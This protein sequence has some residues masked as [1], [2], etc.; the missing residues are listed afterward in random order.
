MREQLTPLDVTFGIQQLIDSGYIEDDESNK[1]DGERAF[2]G[3][4][5]TTALPYHGA[6]RLKLAGNVEKRSLEAALLRLQIEV[7][8]DA[9]FAL[10]VTDDYLR[11]ELSNIRPPWLLVKP[12]GILGSVGPLFL[13]D[14]GP[15]WHCLAARLRENPEVRI[16]QEFAQ[17]W[18][19]RPY[20]IASLSSTS[21]T[22]LQ[23]A[24]TEV[25]KYLATGGTPHLEGTLIT[26]DALNLETRRHMLPRREGCPHCSAPPQPRAAV[27]PTRD[28]DATFHRFEHHISPVTGIV[29]AVG[30]LEVAD[31]SRVHVY[32]AVH[33]FTLQYGRKSSPARWLGSRSI[34]KGTTTVQ[35]RCSSLCEGLERYSGCWRGCETARFCSAEELGDPAVPIESCLLF[36]DCQYAHRDEWNR[37]EGDYNFVPQRFDRARRVAWTELG[38]LTHDRPRYLPA[39]FCYYNVPMEEDHDF[40]RSDSNGNAAGDSLQGAILAGIFEVVERDA[41]AIWWYNQALRSGVEIESFPSPYFSEL[42][43]DYARLDRH[44]WALDLTS[45]FGIPVFVAISQSLTDADE[46]VAGF[47]AHFD[48]QIA[49][50]RAC[51]EVN[52]AI[53]AIES[54]A[55]VRIAIGQW[56]SQDFLHPDPAI[57]PRIFPNYSTQGTGDLARDLRLCIDRARDMGIE[58]LA[59]D[60]TR[61]DVGIPVAKVIMPGMRHFWARFA[62]GRLYNVPSPKREA[63]LN[64]AHLIL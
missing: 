40:C 13:P 41:A 36:S 11:P 19:E 8:D 25:Y 52:Q 20:S 22:I 39:A 30:P 7:T 60:Q 4:L 10:V 48:A 5:G 29:A 49:L 53:A 56:P 44:L 37:R 38:S 16:L 51:T 6:V 34:G 33:N 23:L 9:Q 54:G 18:D 45:D 62:P 15:C 26:L 32:A 24:A 46:P 63:D 21:E 1:S 43:A 3:L 61:A 57:Q 27:I 35:A 12:T 14:S 47:G 58:I 64:P 17:G 42:L 55:T 50:T 59:L 28:P 31:A 2:L